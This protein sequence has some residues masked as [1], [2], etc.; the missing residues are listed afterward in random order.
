MSTSTV[1]GRAVTGEPGGPQRGTGARVAKGLGAALLLVALVVGIP[2]GLWILGGPVWTGPVSLNRVISTLSSP[3]V[4]GSVLL[5]LVKAV[6]WIAWLTF[7]IAVVI[8]VVAALRGRRS[9]HVRGLGAQQRAAAVLVG[10]VITM[11]VAA[12]AATPAMAAPSPVEA[13]QTGTVAAAAVLPGASVVA[14]A[15]TEKVGRHAQADEAPS[16]TYTVQPGDSLWRIAERTLGDGARFKQI[17]DHNAGVPQADG[18]ALDAGNWIE[19]GWVLRLPAASG[20]SGASGVDQAGSGDSDGTVNVRNRGGATESAE[21][22][23]DDI[24]AQGG[25]G[26]DVVEQ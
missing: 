24:D 13:G 2:I 8:E 23:P 1:Q 7:A 3:D 26:N 9:P 21:V 17:A 18:G 16:A 20:A 25:S 12:P 6:G 15:P 14:G 4:T 5:G 22:E 19:P 10:A 11:L